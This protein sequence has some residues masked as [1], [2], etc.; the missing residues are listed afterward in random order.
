MII[1]NSYVYGL[2][3]SIF[4]SGYAMLERAPSE[5]E[6]IAETNFIANCIKNN[7]LNNKHIQRAIKLSHSKVG[8][9]DQFLTGIIVQGD[10]TFT[11]KVWVEAE[12]YK[13]FSFIT[14]MSTMHRMQK[15]DLTHSYD[16]HVDERVIKVVQDI[17]NEYNQKPSEN[18]FL[19]LVY[20]NPAG[21]NL[22]SS[23]TTNYR[24]LKN[25]YA[26]RVNHR[27]KDWNDFCEWVETLPLAKE[28]IL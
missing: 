1:K 25:M 23:M 11:N 24:C 16:K 19:K 9:H 15:F 26:Q 14:S 13:F 12:R 3:E 28:L 6:F 7:N 20:S 2:A 21:F 17:L 18:T 8:G 10:F 5:E 4:R 27:L 22:M